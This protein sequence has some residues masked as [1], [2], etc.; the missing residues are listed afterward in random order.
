MPTLLNCLFDLSKQERMGQTI[1]RCLYK[2]I[3]QMLKTLLTENSQRSLYEA[4]F[5]PAYLQETVLFYQQE[6]IQQ[7]QSGAHSYLLWVEQTLEQEEIKIEHYLDTCSTKE[8]QDCLYK[9]LIVQHIQRLVE[10]LNFLFRW[11]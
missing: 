6:S 1:D 4:V 3:I 9:V 2:D 10:V 5:L 7:L 11:D 8:I